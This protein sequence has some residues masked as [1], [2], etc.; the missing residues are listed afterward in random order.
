MKVAFDWDGT[1][2]DTMPDLAAIAV[3]TIQ[4]HAGIPA[5][6]IS[7]RY[8]QTIGRPFED[9]LPLILRGTML[10]PVEHK[11]ILSEYALAKRTFYTRGLFRVSQ[12]QTSREHS[13]WVVSSTEPDLIQPLLPPGFSLFFNMHKKQA[14]QSLKPDVFLGDAPYDKR[15]AVRAGVPFVPFASS[16]PWSAEP[17]VLRSMTTESIRE[18]LAWIKRN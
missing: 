10:S 14:L 3:R 11:S 12:I 9:Q 7:S 18:V 1:L 4:H 5:S 8:W 13:Y 17:Y 16:Y 2:A 6:I 15:V